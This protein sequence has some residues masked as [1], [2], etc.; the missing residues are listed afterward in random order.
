MQSLVMQRPSLTSHFSLITWN[1]EF[2]S[3]RP[4]SCANCILNH[5][6]KKLRAPDIIFLQEVRSDVCASLLGNPKVCEAFL[7][8][9]AHDSTSFED[10]LFA[11]MTLLSNKCFASSLD[12]P[13]EGDRTQG[14]E[15]FM[16]RPVSHVEL[17]STTRR[18]GLCVDIIP[19]TALDTVCCLINMHLDSHQRLANH[20]QQLKIL[21][22]ILCEP[23]CS[24]GLIA[25]DFNSISP[26]DQALVDDNRLEDA[27]LALHGST[28]SDAP[29]WSVSREQ[30]VGLKLKRLD[31]V[32]IMGLRVEEMEIL[33]QEKGVW[34][35]RNLGCSGCL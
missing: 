33:H 23:G 24:G 14:E 27:W 18:D 2:L 9:D 8:T 31:K 12:S 29:T 16:L 13:G 28:D 5:I 10:K 3:S 20:T 34:P 32:A 1:I 26:E 21:A 7:M 4:V 19:P 30:E 35:W 11:T 15:K 22:N 6:L 17:L 25:G